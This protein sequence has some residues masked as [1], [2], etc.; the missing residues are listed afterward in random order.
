M[1]R[2]LAISFLML[3]LRGN[4][5]VIVTTTEINYTLDSTSYG[6]DPY[7]LWEHY[8]AT[9]FYCMY[10]QFTNHIYSI[11]NS[12]DSLEA[13]YESHQQERGM[14]LWASFNV[15]SYD[16]F[17]ATENGGYA[18]TNPV[19]QWGT[20]LFNA[21][22]LF[23]DG[24]S[25]TN[26]G[27]VV[28]QTITHLALGAIPDQT[29]AVPGNLQLDIGCQ[30]LNNMYGQ[31]S[32]GLYSNLYIGGWSNYF[33]LPQGDFHSGGHPPPGYALD[34]AGQTVINLGLDTNVGAFTLD[35]NNQLV[36][37][38]NKVTIV[39]PSLVNHVL[40]FT[41]HFDRMP[42]AWDVPD[43]TITNDA[44][45]AFISLPKMATQFTWIV[46]ITNLPPGNYNLAIDG[47]NVVIL[48]DAQLSAGWNMF[49]VTNGPLWNQRKAVLNAK[50][51]QQGVDHVTLISHS[52]G[53]Q[54]TLGVADMVNFK[55]NAAQQYGTNGKRG[56]TYITAISSF[57]GSVQQYDVAIHN[58][59]VQTN[60]TF[61][62][63]YIAP[64]Y[65][66]AIAGNVLPQGQY[67]LAIPTSND[68]WHV[69]YSPGLN[70]SNYIWKIAT[71]TKFHGKT[72]FQDEATEV[73][74]SILSWR[75]EGRP[76]LFTLL[77]GEPL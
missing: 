8:L 14:P 4:S 27:S 58:A 48:T 29:N 71:S 5:A 19:I 11:G 55:S 25:I 77:Y 54:G 31:P 7:H 34:M 61:T 30:M 62:V 36:A 56:A 41:A 38:T 43:G 28:A 32:I 15:A 18:T 21:P 44:S 13:Q 53:S 23:W 35:W 50:R 57:V 45:T 69:F 51:D 12:G 37:A 20:N 70:P 68:W 33:R 9:Y 10:P 17:I 16:F 22:P 72:N 26:E 76:T 66:G 52:A 73:E 46:Q 47:S 49:A 63:T 67:A 42:M 64:R 24:T 3:S 40:T 74:G 59:A 60:H 6:D 2:L 75:K 1:K 65:V 39:N